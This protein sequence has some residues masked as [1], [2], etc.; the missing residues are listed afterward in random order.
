MSEAER[1][2]LYSYKKK[3]VIPK[4]SYMR[5]SVRRCCT[6]RMQLRTFATSDLWDSDLWSVGPVDP[7]TY[8]I[9][10]CESSDLCNVGFVGFGLMGRRTYGLSDL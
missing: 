5:C 8:E 3:R 9:R 6:G 2:F 4:K 1:D 10:T 7:R